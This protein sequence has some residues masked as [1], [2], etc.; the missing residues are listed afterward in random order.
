MHFPENARKCAHFPENARKCAHFT[1]D[2]TQQGNFH[3]ELLVHS[4]FVK[5]FDENYYMMEKVILDLVQ[6]AD[7]IVL[8]KSV[9]AAN[10]TII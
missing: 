5:F 9:L 1:K 4:I 6:M 2:L 7:L 8:A 3:S 10:L